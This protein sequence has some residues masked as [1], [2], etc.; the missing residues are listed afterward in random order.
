MAQASDTGPVTAP[1]VLRL[2]LTGPERA[3]LDQ[4]AG[5]LAKTPPGLVDDPDWVA[6]ARALS[7]HLPP[8]LLEMIRR[9]RHDPG[10]EGVL[11]I[12]NLPVDAAALPPTPTVAGS[13]E[14][15]ATV[16]ACVAVLVTLQLGEI[17]AYR[18]EKSGALV[19]NVVPVHGRESSQSNAGSVPLE[20]HV[21]NAF[22]PHRPDYVGLL[23]L[24]S[25]REGTGGTLT[26]SIRTVLPMLREEDREVLRR[27]RFVTEPPPSFQSSGAAEPPRHPL[28]EGDP[29]DPNVRVDFFATT[30]VDVEAAQAMSHLRTAFLRA[31]R[32]LLL[33][34]GEMAIVD[35]RVV[36]HGRTAFTPRYDGE[37][38]WL[39]R[40]FVSLDNRRSRAHR[41]GNGPVMD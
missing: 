33:A 37:D 16:P 10:P 22:H 29:A 5:R 28:L 4:L 39:H 36:V 19:Q 34:S 21:E 41:T 13:V 25:E 8:R 17:V 24:R 2:G 35:N 9:Y 27:P 40:T 7:C 15:A 30:P 6:E 18:E 14:R 3:D 1:D 32:P 23:S 38:R 20:M 26:S 31:S 11:V 12:G